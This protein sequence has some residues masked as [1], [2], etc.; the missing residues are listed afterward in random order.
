M[1]A[2]PFLSF[3]GK[4]APTLCKQIKDAL[5]LAKDFIGHLTDDNGNNNFAGTAFNGDR[6]LDR[7]MFP[8][9]EVPIEKPH[10]TQAA[11]LKLAHNWIDAMGGEF[12]GD[13]ACG[14]EPSHYLLRMSAQTTVAVEDVRYEAAMNPVDIPIEFNDDG[15]FTGT[16][17]ADFQ[18]AGVGGDC[19]MSA[20]ANV[21]FS[22]SGKAVE[23]LNEQSMH[24]KLKTASP[25]DTSG[26]ARCPERSGSVQKALTSQETWPFDG[27]GKVGEVLQTPMPSPGPGI[28]TTNRLEIVKK[29]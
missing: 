14:C 13:K 17:T 27:Q 8:E 11:F 29:D 6:G 24:I 23:T 15:T 9:S 3:V 18:G 5:H 2:P 28:T 1:T 12:Q 7:S 16:G 20:T 22:V 21:T 10:I 26:T 25:M 19:T 4:D